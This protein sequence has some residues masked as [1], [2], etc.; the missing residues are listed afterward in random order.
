M[1]FTSGS[2][3]RFCSLW[4]TLMIVGGAVLF[5][6]VI[7]GVKGFWP[8]VV[9]IWPLIVIMISGLLMYKTCKVLRVE[10]RKDRESCKIK[11]V[12]GGDV[13]F[14]KSAV[15]ADVKIRPIIAHPAARSALTEVYEII[16]VRND[17]PVAI[18]TLQKYTCEKAVILETVVGDKTLAVS[19]ARE[20]RMFIDRNDDGLP[21][22]LEQMTYYST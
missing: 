8:W 2:Y 18:T 19:R 7:G 5:G 15:S 9:T 17:F 22:I 20:I 6:M 3:G 1:K 4:I 11:M 16:L 12:L 14:E 21:E 13:V 10:L